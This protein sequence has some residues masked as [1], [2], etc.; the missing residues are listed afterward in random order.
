MY[1]RDPLRCFIVG[2]GTL[3]IQC[4]EI[5]LDR[6]HEICGVMSRD[7]SILRWAEGKA[8]SH[9]E[10]TDDLILFM[11]RR[12]VDYLFSIVN[13]RILPKKLLELPGRYAINYHD[14]LLPK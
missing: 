3:P 2:E 6:G 10:T 9:I 4:G 1:K 14:A 7:A 12:P 11:S 5:L 13:N 8:V